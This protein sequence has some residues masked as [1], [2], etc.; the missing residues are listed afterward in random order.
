MQ[1]LRNNKLFPPIWGIYSV[2]HQIILVTRK[3][4]FIQKPLS[5]FKPKC[6]QQYLYILFSSSLQTPVEC[7]RLPYINKVF[8]PHYQELL[9]RTLMMKLKEKLSFLT[10]TVL[11]HINIRLILLSKMLKKCMIR[12][13]PCDTEI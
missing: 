4:V 5:I 10:S 3:K 9:E 13:F 6:L 1:R 12:D 7:M 11:Q 2:N 8:I